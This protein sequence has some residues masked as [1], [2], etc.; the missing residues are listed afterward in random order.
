LEQIS[1]TFAEYR[2]YEGAFSAGS[3]AAFQNGFAPTPISGNYAKI[4]ISDLDF[5]RS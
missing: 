4:G 2:F 1:P 5:H 3:M